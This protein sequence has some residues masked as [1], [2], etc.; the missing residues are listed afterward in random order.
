MKYVF[1]LI[2]LQIS[3]QLFFFFWFIYLKEHGEDILS[4]SFMAPNTLATGS[5]DGEIVIWNTNSELATHHCLQRSR[6]NFKS[7]WSTFSTTSVKEVNFQFFFQLKMSVFHTKIWGSDSVFS[8]LVN[9]SF[10]HTCYIHVVLCCLYH[11]ILYQCFLTCF[12]I[13]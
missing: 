13:S 7:R 12:G 6:S 3:L 4:C 5:Y 9:I 8:F 1:R 10:L 2:E 11:F